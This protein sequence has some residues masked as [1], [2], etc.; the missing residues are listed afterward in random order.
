MIEKNSL[1][2]ILQIALQ[3]GGDFAEVYLEQKKTTELPVKL[4]KLRG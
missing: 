1:E 3:K 2:E 4:I